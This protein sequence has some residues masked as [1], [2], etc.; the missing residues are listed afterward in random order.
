MNN[1]G[2]C[3]AALDLNLN[4]MTEAHDITLINHGAIAEQVVGQL[5]RTIYP[6]YIQP[7]LYYW[8]REEKNSNAEVD[9]L[10]SHNGK[11]I[12]IE[13]KAGSTGS[14]KSLHLMMELKKLKLAIRVNADFPKKTEVK[15][16][17]QQGELIEYTL[18]SIPFYLIGEINRLLSL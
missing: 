14:L 9:Y 15:V 16:K 17:N 18:L 5:L 7:A 13:V 6:F 1:V 11:I 4:Y 2:L 3:S 8:V 12:P 10:I